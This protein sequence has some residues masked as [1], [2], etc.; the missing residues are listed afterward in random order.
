MAALAHVATECSTPIKLEVGKR[1]VLRNG[2]ITGPLKENTKESAP[3]LFWCDVLG[4]SWDASGNYCLSHDNHPRD[5]ISEYIEPQESPQQPAPEKPPLQWRWM[6]P[7]RAGIWAYASGT[8][9]EIPVMEA[10]VYLESIAQCED[11]S[12]CW[13]CFICDMPEI[14]PPKT[15]IQILCVCPSE[16]GDDVQAKWFDRDNVQDGWHIST[17]TREVTVE[18]PQQ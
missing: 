10:V 11:W 7:D 12:I 16:R 15:V 1:Y 4:V 14:S 13:H 8:N 2:L 3:Y 17:L 5:I 18:E 9:N 6:R